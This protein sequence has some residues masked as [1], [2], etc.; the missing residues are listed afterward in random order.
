MDLVRDVLA[1]VWR[2][3]GRH[4]EIDASAQTIAA[5]LASHLPL[6]SLFVLRYDAAPQVLQ[7][8]ASI[9][10]GQRTPRGLPHFALPSDQAKRL[11]AWGSTG[12]LRAI[13][14]KD[15]RRGL[16]FLLPSEP[17]GEA[18]G[19]PLTDAEGLIGV[20][21]FVAPPSKPFNVRQRN[22]AQGAARTLIGGVGAMIGV[23]T[24]WP[25]CARRRRPNA[26]LCSPA[27][28]GNEFKKRSSGPTPACGW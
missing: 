23:C 21:L 3:V 13:S 27:S 25:L 14:R 11:R 4:I 2:E 17:R 6:E 28:G 26:V 5:M 9:D 7:T 16:G 10:R 20:V 8:V 22:L 1:E 24:S 15:G 19:G 12:E 18:W